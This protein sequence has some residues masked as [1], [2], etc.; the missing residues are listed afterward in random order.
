[1]TLT[2]RPC[3][4]RMRTLCVA[5]L[6][7]VCARVSRGMSRLPPV[8]FYRKPSEHRYRAPPPPWA[9]AVESAADS[10]MVV[11]LWVCRWVWMVVR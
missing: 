7:R 11:R 4:V 9:A 10:V 8:S 5:R 1:M 3:T 2:V 6:P